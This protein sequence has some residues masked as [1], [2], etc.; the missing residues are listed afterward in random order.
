MGKT[1]R[2]T[3]IIAFALK[4]LQ[5]IAG[6]VLIPLITEIIYSNKALSY[7][8]EPVKELLIS[9]G[10][11]FVTVIIGLVIPLLYLG[12]MFALIA[13][14]KSQKSGIA[15]EVLG[16]ICMGLV[17]P[18]ISLVSSIIFTPVISRLLSNWGSADSFVIYTVMRS[19]GG[20]LSVL[21]TISLVLLIVSFTV[22][23]CR[24]KWARDDEFEKGM[25]E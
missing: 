3:A 24:K 4:V 22:S 9:M 12:F 13:A 18:V 23:L 1:I 16:L 15:L 7:S 2:I 8:S 25:E 17:I 19:S 11:Y 14:S 6:D 5:V 20:Y 21:G 10:I